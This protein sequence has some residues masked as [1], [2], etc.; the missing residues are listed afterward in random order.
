[1]RPP[2]ILARLG[3]M[4]EEINW[5]LI[6]ER[7]HARQCV[8]FLGAGVN[9]SSDDYEGL[10]LGR[11]VA[12]RLAEELIAA[13]AQAVVARRLD[14]FE[15]LAEVK[16]L[17]QALAVYPD[18][19]RLAVQDLARVAFYVEQETDNP[20]LRQLLGRL[21]PD[22]ER[23]PSGI[24]QA[25]AS[26]PFKVIV[27][28]NYDRL[29]EDAL[30]AA[31]KPYRTVVQ[32]IAGFDPVE[33]ANLDDEL[34]TL[35]AEGTLILYKIHGS[36]C[37]EPENGDRPADRLLIT[38]EDYIEFL[39][40]VSDEQMGIPPSIKTELSTSTLLFLGYGLEDWD[41][42]T[43]FKATIER[44]G[45]HKIFKSFAIQHQ[46][47]DFWVRFWERGDKNVTIYDVD[48]H[49]FAARLRELYAEYAAHLGER[50]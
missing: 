14:D 13:K 10:P 12:L 1:L 49:E 11:Q 40:V 33:M 17:E 45:R 26:M 25:L 20:H 9:V 42:R 29:M 35:K 44:L 8:P 21:L 7:I 22:R 46:P 31:R 48:L 39:T 41:F 27:T 4:P 34:V 6:V 18:L 30:D 19:M 2:A 43:L 15:D 5:R 50:A 3:A 38:E 24:L 23:E 28:T 36:F 37:D 47:M 16:L 32:P